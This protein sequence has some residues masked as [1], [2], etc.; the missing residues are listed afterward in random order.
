MKKIL[1]LLF[2]SILC[3]NALSAQTKG[4]ILLYGSVTAYSMKSA[5]GQKSTFLRA[6]PGVGYN[7]SDNWAVGI[8]GMYDLRRDVDTG[9]LALKTKSNNWS[10]GP[11]IRYSQPLGDLFFIFGQFELGYGQ[12]TAGI[13]SGVPYPKPDLYNIS[14]SFFP[15]VGLELNNGFALNFA[16]GGITYNYSK[17][18]MLPDA[19]QSV[20]LNFG[21]AFQFGVSKFFG[22]NGRHAAYQNY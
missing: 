12:P 10:V 18:K 8:A 16:F 22:D 6:A 3:T 4:Q 1:Y 15:S 7:L 17:T 13:K 14:A 9:V 5:W 20:T 19:D 11:F 2:I 21:H